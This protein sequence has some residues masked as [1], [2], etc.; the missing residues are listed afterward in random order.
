MYLQLQNCAPACAALVAGM[1]LSGCGGGNGDA[2]NSEPSSLANMSPAQACAAVKSTMIASSTVSLPTGGITIDSTALQPAAGSG[3]TAIGE[4]C[5]VKGHIASVNR[6]SPPINFQVNLPSTWNGKGF[7]LMGGGY[8][9]T[10]V[11][12]TG[13]APSSA[14][15]ATPILIRHE[16][17]PGSRH[18]PPG[19]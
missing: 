6:S 18:E 14:G 11:T 4:Y 1:A 13:S 2:G 5:E 7:H 15:F 9:G 12:G 17:Q 10:L 19:P 3:T 8:D 16:A